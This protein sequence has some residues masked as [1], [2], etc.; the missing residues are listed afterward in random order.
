M[1][2]ELGIMDF[3]K[4]TPEQQEQMKKLTAEQQDQINQVEA[5]MEIEGMPLT[6]QARQDLIDIAA[7]RKTVEQ[8]IEETKKRYTKTID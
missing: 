5:T 1:R 8:V 7:G 3:E 2:K 4:I 6:E